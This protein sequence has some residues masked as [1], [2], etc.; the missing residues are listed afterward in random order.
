MGREETGNKRGMGEEGGGLEE[1][2]RRREL[3]RERRLRERQGGFL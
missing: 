2:E 1:R 3:R